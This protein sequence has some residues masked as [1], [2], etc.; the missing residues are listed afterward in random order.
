MQL[1]TWTGLQVCK[2]GY[3]YV[4]HYVCQKYI[5]IFYWSSASLLWQTQNQTGLSGPLLIKTHFG[6]D[7]VAWS[8]VH[9]HL[10]SEK[11]KGI[12]FIFPSERQNVFTRILFENYITLRATFTG[13]SSFAEIPVISLIQYM[14]LASHLQLFCIRMSGQNALLLKGIFPP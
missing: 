6:F 8:L 14:C 9:V 5:K 2:W 13:L 10:P 12:F 4:Q 11:E 3:K 1:Q 7:S